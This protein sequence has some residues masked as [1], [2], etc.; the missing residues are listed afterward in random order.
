MIEVRFVHR[1]RYRLQ[2]TRQNGNMYA[3]GSSVAVASRVSTGSYPDFES[4]ILYQRGV[5]S[6][7]ETHKQTAS[8][9]SNTLRLIAAIEICHRHGRRTRSLHSNRK[10]SR[11]DYRRQRLSLYQSGTNRVVR[12]ID[13]GIFPSP[14]TLPQSPSSNHWVQHHSAILQPSVEGIINILHNSLHDKRRSGGGY[15]LRSFSSPEASPRSAVDASST[16]PTSVYAIFR[17]FSNCSLA[18]ATAASRRFESSASRAP[19]EPRRKQG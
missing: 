7:R 1:E 16:N 19:F 17:N 12:L 14:M 8:A 3:I 13:C 11:Q 2:L 5:N 15:R 9:L 10:H 18:T 6:H 4:E